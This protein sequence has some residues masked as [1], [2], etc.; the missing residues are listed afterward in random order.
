M[1]QH[2][3]ACRV[4]GNVDT[5]SLGAL[6]D[7]ASFAGVR[8]QYPISGGQ[9]FECSDCGLLFRHPVL[10]DEAY[11]AL[12]T[13]G[14]PD[15]WDVESVRSDFERVRQQIPAAAI[16]VLD[17]GC[18]TGQLLDSLRIE[19]RRHGV[20]PNA[21]AA[22]RARERGIRIV[23]SH[24]RE[25]AGGPMYDVI[26]ACDVIEHVVDP[27]DFLVVLSAQLKPGGRL[28]ITTGNAEAW[29]W[30]LMGTRF[31]YCYWP[32]HISFVS[33]R[34]WR[35]MADRCGLTITAM[36]P[37]RHTPPPVVPRMLAAV[38]QLALYW[39]A[40]PLYWRLRAWWA[41]PDCGELGPPG[42]ANLS[43]DHLLCELQK[44]SDPAAIAPLA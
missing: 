39:A 13:A 16:D 29:L 12:Y 24:W 7:V 14:R 11:T 43:K 19:C 2:N 41:G 32:E 42:G 33:P 21:Q 30:K 26:V 9:L 1:N 4:C 6:S 3:P 38:A 27:H 34:W 18:Y 20:E 31:W 23:A 25:I 35:W 28:I 40:R 17:V 8:L 44:A 36:L 37:F 22:A 10:D 5:R 15:V